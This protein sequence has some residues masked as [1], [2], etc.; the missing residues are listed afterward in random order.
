MLSELSGRSHNVFSGVTLICLCAV[1]GSYVAHLRG[2]CVVKSFTERTEV[3]MAELSPELIQGS[4]SSLLPSSLCGHE[5]AHGQGG[6]L[7][8]SGHR[9]LSDF[10]YSR[11]LLQR[12]CCCSDGLLGHGVPSLPFLQ[13]VEGYVVGCFLYTRLQCLSQ[14]YMNPLSSQ[15]SPTSI[16][17]S[18]INDNSLFFPMHNPSPL[19]TNKHPSDSHN[20]NSAHS[21]GPNRAASPR[22][23]PRQPSCMLFDRHPPCRPS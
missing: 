7:R 6:Q 15:L 5:G 23:S 9:R 14:F 16:C 13:G 17:I 10:G 20:R 12:T 2:E 19:L 21:L 22:T 3:E 8:H 11:L 4:V 18:L 1:C